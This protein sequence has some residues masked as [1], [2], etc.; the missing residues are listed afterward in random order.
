[1]EKVPEII[2]KKALEDNDRMKKEKLESEEF[3]LNLF[4]TNLEEY[5]KL[6]EEN[7]IDF[8]REFPDLNIEKDDKEIDFNRVADR[9]AYMRMQEDHK[10]L[11]TDIPK[12]ELEI[13]KI[14]TNRGR[15]DD[16]IR[17]NQEN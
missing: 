6:Y 2:M 8:K 5:K 1:M 7:L 11:K 12:I 3:T 15:R 14:E 4:K 9:E 16:L 10:R 17:T 13:K